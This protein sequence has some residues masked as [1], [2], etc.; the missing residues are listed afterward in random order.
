MYSEIR[1]LKKNPLFLR[2]CCFTWS[3]AVRQR[4]SALDATS[5]SFSSTPRCFGLFQLAGFCC[6]IATISNLTSEKRSKSTP[7]PLTDHLH[8]RFLNA[9]QRSQKP[10]DHVLSAVLFHPLLP[11]SKVSQKRAIISCHLKH[12][13]QF[14]YIFISSSNHYVQQHFKFLILHLC[15][16]EPSENIN[17]KGKI[18][19]TR[20]SCSTGTY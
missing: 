7:F 6:Q 4:V 16:E 3:E 1:L 11:L 17:P 5:A 2:G 13:Y 18:P 8:Q 20:Q 14:I 10:A 9:H 12:A 19:I 15:L